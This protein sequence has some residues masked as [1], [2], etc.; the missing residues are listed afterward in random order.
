MCWGKDVELSA[1]QK[2]IYFDCQL[3]DPVSYNLCATILFENINEILFENAFKLLIAEQEM[4]RCSLKIIN[5]FPSLV[6]YDQIEFQLEKRDYSNTEINQQK[7]ISQFAEEE[8]QTAFD[9][10]VPPLFRAQL[11]KLNTNQHMLI[12]C[13]HHIIADGVSFNILTKKLL[14]FHCKLHDRNR[15]V[16]KKDTGFSQFI[17]QENTNL[18]QGKYEKQKDF[19]MQ[20]LMGV[21]PLSLSVDYST[22]Q[23]KGIGKEKRF[24][25]QDDLMQAMNQLA[26][27]Q[28]VTV[29]M[30]FLAVFG[31]LISRY[32]QSEEIVLTSPFSYRADF[33]F[34]E[35]IGCFIRMLYLRF[36]IKEQ[37]SFAVIL[38][39]VAEELILA[40]KNSDYPSNL[41]MRNNLQPAITTS[42]SI[43]DVLFVYDVYEEV[44]ENNL[45][46]NMISQDHVTFPGSLMIILNKMPNEDLL[47]IQYKPDVFKDETINLLGQRFLQLLKILISD[48]NI[49][50]S[51]IN[52]LLENE[53]S[54]SQ[55]DLQNS[56][57]SIWKDV[58]GIDHIK[59]D[60]N[61]FDVGGHSLALIQVNNK[62]KS[63]N[64]ELPIRTHFQLPTVRSLVEH[65][66]KTQK[67]TPVAAKKEFK[68]NDRK[69]HQDI[70]IIGLAV[71]VPGAE[72]L[73]EFWD[74][75]KNEKE[76]IHFY[77]DDELL[78]LGIPRET[79]NSPN[80][81]KAIGRVEGIDFFDHNF[82]EY[83]PAEVNLMSPQLRLLH[84]GIWAAFEDAG[85]YPDSNF[86]T[87][88]VFLGGSDDFEW[89][90]D[91]I[92]N[93]N[94]YNLKYQAFTLSTNHFLATRIAYK[95]DIKGPVFTALS[96]CSSTLVTTHLA[97]QSL[98]LG[99][100]D[101][102]IAGGITIELPN[103]GGY[104]YEEGMMFSPDGHCRP[105]DT[106]AAGT[107]FSN[108]MGLV[109]LKRLEEAL[110]D[111]D[112]IYAVIKGSAVNNDGAQKMGYM[113]PSAKGQMD[114]IQSAYRI[115]GIDPETISYVEAHGTGTSLGDPIEVESLTQAF[116]TNKKQF[117][118]LSSVKG[119]IGHPDTAA[120]VVGLAK[121]ALSFK[122]R[123]IPGTVNYQTANPKIDFANSPFI[124]KSRGTKWLSQKGNLLR[125][126]INSFGVGGTNV[127]MVLEEAPASTESHAAAQFNLLVFSAKSSSAVSATAK[128]ILEFV[129][130]NPDLNLSDVAWTLQVGRKPFAFRKTLIVDQNLLK[131][132]EML[133]KKLDEA[134]IYETQS[135]NKCVFFMFSGQGSQYQGMARDLYYSPETTGLAAIFKRHFSTVVELL[136]S[137]ERNDFLEIIFGHDNPQTINETQHSQFALFAISYTLAQM[138]IEL[139][140]KPR[141]MLGHSVG[142]LTAAT[143]AGVLELK[144][145]I[146]IVKLRGRIMQKQQPGTMLA[147]MCDACAVQ[148]E[149][150]SD[151]WLALDNT[152]HS[153][154]VG[155]SE[156]AIIEFE[157]K[158]EKLDWVTAR[159]KTS[160]AFH[161]PM[162]QKAAEEFCEKIS[163]YKL[164]EPNIPLVSNVSGEWVSAKEMISPNYWASHI[165]S[166]VNFTKCLTEVLKSDDGIYIEIGPGQILSSF[167]KQHADKTN[168]QHFINLIRHPKEP[169]NDLEYLNKKIGLLWSVGVDIDWC[170]LKGDAR[171]RRVSL[172]AYVFDKIYFPIDVKMQT[173][174]LVVEKL[175]Q[176]IASSSSPLA[177]GSSVLQNQDQ[178]EYR[179]IEAYKLVLGFETITGNQDFFA[180]GGDSL[181][182]VSLA[183]AIKT[184]FGVKIDL[185]D[186]F[187][188]PTPS[189]LAEY[190]SKNSVSVQNNIRIT[191]VAD[192]NFY[193]LSSAQR[194]M[195]T[196]YLLDKNSVAYNLPSATLI[197]GK[198]DKK[199]F[200]QALRKLVIRHEPLRTRFEIHNNEP[201]QMIHS[202]FTVPLVYSKAH[203]TNDE[204]INQ[205]IYNFIKPFDLQQ[206]PLFRAQLIELDDNQHLFLFDIHHIIADGTSMEIISR[207][208]NQLYVGELPLL[209][210]QYRDF[211]VWQN[212]YLKSDTLTAQKNFW[213]NCLSGDLPSLD[214]P[215]DFARPTVRQTGGDR[216]YFK[217]DTTLT[218]KLI[219]FSQEAGTTLF[220]TFLSAWNVLLARY[221]NQEDIIVGVPIAGR[222]HQ[223]IEE[224]VGMFVNMLPI[225]SRPE[226]AKTFGEFLSEVKRTVLEAF[227]NQEYQFD[228]LVQQLNLKRDLSR[229]ALFD[230]CFD[231]Q[232]MQ[233]YDLQVEDITFT[234]HAFKTTTTAY[235]LV[236]TCQEHKQEGIIQGFL[237]YSTTLFKKETIKRI[238]ANFQTILAGI[239]KQKTVVL[240]NI[241]VVSSQEQQLICSTFNDTSL[242]LNQPLPVQ[243]MF[244]QNA[245]KFPEK[246]ALIV[247][248]GEKLTYGELNQ[249]ANS[250]ASH[251]SKLGLQKDAIVAV[252]TE[253]NESLFIALLA[254][255]K[256]GGAFLLIDPALPSERIA[257]MIEQCNAKF[258]I[259]SDGYKNKI[260]FTDTTITLD[261]YDYSHT[262][263]CVPVEK[264]QQ[265]DLAY[266]MF[267]S[268]S[269]GKPK[270]VMINQSS[271][272]NFIQDIKNRRIF[273]HQEDRVICITTVSFDIFLFESIVPLCTGHSIYL[274]NELEQLDPV[275]ANKKIMDHK[276]T[277]IVSTISRI[278][279]FIENLKFNQALKQLKCI[280]SGGEN[281]PI[282]LLKDLKLKS[283][284]K[285][286]N[287]YGPTETTIWSTTKD[288]TDTDEINI[289]KPIANTQAYIINLAGKLQ[290][291]GVFGEL[292]LAG[293][294][295]TR[296]YLNLQDENPFFQLTDV[297]NSKIY[298]T[299]DRARFLVSGE[300]EI[301]GRLDSQIKLR[302]YRIELSEIEKLAMEHDDISLAVAV[303]FNDSNDNK[304]LALYYCFKNAL[305]NSIRE[306]DWLQNW[307][308]GK[309]PSYMIPTYFMQLD[310]MPVLPSGKINKKALPLPHQQQGSA[311]KLH[312]SSTSSELEKTILTLWKEVLCIDQI[313]LDDNFFDL[314]GHSLGL[315]QINN[316]LSHALGFSIPL[317]QLFEYPTIE[318]L[319]RSLAPQKNTISER[320]GVVEN[321]SS[322]MDIAVIGMACK[323]PGADNI[324]KFWQNIVNGVESITQFSEEEL[325]NSGIDPTL[326]SQ[327]NYI[328]AKG[329]LENAEF[330]D[331]EFFGYSAHE[332][333]IMDPQSRILHQC[334]WEVLEN[335]GY[336]SSNYDGRIGL[337]AGSASNV[338]WMTNLLQDHQNLLNVFEAVTLNEKDFLTTR[339][340]YKLN[341]KGPSFNIQT[342]CSTSLVAIHQAAQSLIN[343]ECDMAIAGGVSVSYPRKEGYL[344]HEGMIFSRDG[345]CKPFADDSSGII[346]GNGCGL[347]LLKPL[348]AALRDGDHIY[349]VIKGSA[350]NNDGIEK[351]GYTAPSIQGQRSVIETALQKSGIV[352]EEI[353]YIEAHGTGT[354]IGDPIEIQALKTAW[355]TD[356]KGFCAI[357]SV[358]ANLGHL[359][360]AAGVAS[361]IKTVLLLFNRKL[362]PLINFKNPNHL[363][364]LE[365]SPFYINVEARDIVDSHQT[366]RAGVSS[367]GIG[368]TNAHVILEQPP[369]QSLQNAAEEINIL[370]FSAK[371]PQALAGTSTKVLNYLENNSAVNISDA[372]WTLQ[373]GRSAFEY[374]KYLVTNGR[375]QSI[376]KTNLEDFLNSAGHKISAIKKA[377][378]F[379]FSGEQLYLEICCDLYRSASK[380]RMTVIFKQILENVLSYFSA[381]EQQ[382]FN[383][384]LAGKINLLQHNQSQLSAQFLF[385][386]SYALA[387]TLNRIGITPD[388]ILGQGV[389][390]IIALVIADVL[391]LENAIDLIKTYHQL[392]NYQEPCT[393]ASI[394]N[395]SIE[396]TKELNEFV[397]KLTSYPLNA[398]TI[399]LLS[400]IHSLSENQLTHSL[401]IE[402]SASKRM[403]HYV[404]QNSADQSTQK[405]IS[406]L[407]KGSDNHLIYLNTVVGEIWCEGVEIDWQKLNGNAFRKR[408]PLPSYEFA[409]QYYNSDIV[410]NSVK[411]HEIES[412]LPNVATIEHRLSQIWCE[413]FGCHKIS[414][415]DDFFALGG[416]SLK[417]VIL[418]AQ[419][420]KVFN[421]EM[422]LTEIFSHA[423]FRQM[424]N[425]LSLNSSKQ[426][427]HKIQPVQKNSY[428]PTSSAQKRMYAVHELLSDSL[429]YN[430]GAV[431]VIEGFLEKEK[432]KIVFDTLGQ[433]HEA[434]R[435]KF[436]IIDGEVVQQIDENIQSVIEFENYNGPHIAQK[437]TEYIRPFDL[438]KAPLFR[439]KLITLA[440]AKH[441]LLVDLHHI[442][443]DQS[444]IIILLREFVD[445]YM[446]KTLAPVHIQYKD[447]AI[448]QNNILQSDT[449]KKQIEFWKNEFDGEIPVLNLP[450]DFPRPPIQR[451]EGERISFE[452]NRELS[453]KIDSFSKRFGLT[454]YMVFMAALKLV[455][456]K[457]TGQNDLIIGTAIA[458]RK[459]ADLLSIVGMFVNTLAIRTQVNESYT[460][461]EYLQYL[462]E[463][464]LKAY[465][466]QD[467]QFEMLIELLAIEKDLSRNPLFD[468]AI[469]YLDMGSHEL[470]LEGL[471]ITPYTDV[472]VYSKFDMTWTIE[473]KSSGY[474]T[475]I[476]FNTSLF[477]L[478][479]MRGF[480]NSLLNCLLFIT[481]D[482]N[483]KLTELSLL[484]AEERNSI[485]YDLNQTTVAY[486]KDKTIIQLF[487]D[488]VQM[489]GNKT[490]VTWNDE[491][492]SYTELNNKANRIAE[493]LVT[494]GIHYGDNIAIL[495]QRSPT[496][497]ACILAILK[498]GG[499]YVPIDPN[500]PHA[501]I[502][503]ILEDSNACL[504]LTHSE[505]DLQDINIHS[506]QL[507]LD[508]DFINLQSAA[509]SPN[510]LPQK[511]CPTDTCYIMYTSGSTGNPKGVLTSHRNVIRVVKDTNYINIVP[512]DK[513]LQLSNYA[514]DGSVFDIFASLL[515]GASLVLLSYEKILE[516][517][518]LAECIK[519][520]QVS[521][522]YITTAL[523]NMLVEWD[524]S[525]L[526]HVRK[527]L[528]G[529]EAA[530]VPHVRKALDFLGPNK[531]IN[532]Y[533]P[534]ET[535]VF[536]TYYPINKL[537]AD[538]YRIPIGYPLSNTKLYI[539][540]K[541][542]QVVP[543][544][545]VGELYIGGD[546]VAKGY[547]NRNELTQ[548]NFLSNPFE[549]NAR[550]YRTGDLVQR[551]STG[552]IIFIGR[553]DFQVKIRG[554]RIEL[555]EIEKHIKEIQGI[556]NA[557]V[558]VKQDSNGN[559]FIAAYYTCVGDEQSSVKPDIIRAKLSEQI[560]EFMIP[561]RMK[562]IS[563]IPLS[564]TGKVDLKALPIIDNIDNTPLNIH[565]S[566]NSIE[567]ILLAEMKKVLDYPGL[568][569]EDDFF[570][571]GGHSIKAISLVHS[572]TKLGFNLKVSDIFQHPTV[573]RL[574]KLP[575]LNQFEKNQNNS[576]F[577]EKNSFTPIILNEKQIDSL[578]AHSYSNYQLLAEIVTSSNEIA[579][580]PLAPVQLFHCRYNDRCSG[581]TN[582]IKGKY[583]E[584]AIRKLL[585]SII[586]NNQLLHCVIHKGVIAE[587]YEYDI[588]NQLIEKYLPYFDLREYEKQTQEH[589]I[590]KLYSV[591]ISSSYQEGSLP[592]RCCCVRL[593]DDEHYII[594]GFD[595]IAF[596]GL[597]SEILRS[598]IENDII[599][600]NNIQQYE[601]Y[602]SLLKLGP[603]NIS[604]NKIIDI[605]SLDKWA[606]NNIL[607]SK[608]LAKLSE[609]KCQEMNVEIPLAEFAS[610]DLWKFSYDLVQKVL[611]EIF[612]I[613]E[614][615][616][617]IVNYGRSYN[618]N[619]F[620]NCVGEFLDIIPLLTMSPRHENYIS[621]LLEQCQKYAINFLALLFDATLR[622]KFPKI[623][624]LLTSAFVTEENELEMV[625]F[626]FQGFVAKEERLKFKAAMSNKN[627]NRLAKFLIIANYDDNN[628]NI[629]L[630]CFGDQATHVK[631]LIDSYL[632]QYRNTFVKSPMD[633]MDYV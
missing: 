263:K 268:G 123:F 463:K 370:L 79:I 330:F 305:H 625:L 298:K 345:H 5:D 280:I 221:T 492:L 166:P 452:I 361:F 456:W 631:K 344:W 406:L 629:N 16:L 251:I 320:S 559:N 467:C 397:H 115:A 351:I 232:N 111:G 293:R 85:Y 303:A 451:F 621:Y 54:V 577:A 271:V 619:N 14:D 217:I 310:A 53:S 261:S 254:I 176:N 533:G 503:F 247:S 395:N 90:R 304:Q 255:L 55:M 80:Y 180:L 546:G 154:V 35:S 301:K 432:F 108:G 549:K 580:F 572:L 269:T 343:N 404:K 37:E 568:E 607:I 273:Q 286:F 579:R 582:T 243:E 551:L 291:I 242:D 75:L 141:A 376:D 138:L 472:S 348:C 30:F 205:L 69:L 139:G 306:K 496:Q 195:Y 32:V 487:D 393:I 28:E 371:S 317:L 563:S 208:F 186:I 23:K 596:D 58:L 591:F 506:I 169:A 514:F 190:L 87:I 507:D 333:E 486:P 464:T 418:A 518:S 179:I 148:K 207:D 594:W 384:I 426:M 542:G 285:I 25:I 391:S 459:H 589:I 210:I 149:L 628:L 434:L 150:N 609:K 129:H 39:R 478:E 314:G 602:V 601:N 416:D 477:K 316:K 461:E 284:A 419:I 45:R 168:Q 299:G 12:F 201:A 318:S 146:E 231:F 413:M 197:K 523:F 184:L 578:V 65:F 398:P 72:T 327:P 435:T 521:V 92:I 548:Q 134:L 234:P 544:N 356:K 409:K 311:D 608:K 155:G 147:V 223:E 212:D 50:I 102:A 64:L 340:S 597:S 153:C 528:F 593:S 498:C 41:I 3:E 252:M 465:E 584:N 94:N 171:R 98:M 622:T 230:V 248:N 250:L 145:A 21:Q 479:T 173:S 556:K 105:F 170:V 352:A 455:L 244:E 31:V 392:I 235:D 257:Y 403:L 137:D 499:T 504:V 474:Q 198:L 557:V 300:L 485:V 220:M 389:G 553:V 382:L 46:A 443:A 512:S 399:P 522:F 9:L 192:R 488:Q 281:F 587:W 246:T 510:Y 585:T 68:R 386:I 34:E 237:D 162:M 307:L 126:G 427:F 355:K 77:T 233:F 222:V 420:Q 401:F 417:A 236:L 359:D 515:N 225:R 101:L 570:K 120:G 277:H 508:E 505:L 379:L 592:W 613:S 377:V 581:F 422:P 60:D 513:L 358:K 433:R 437:I 152:S 466:N 550:I 442:I 445:L 480:I 260:K 164:N 424:I 600:N 117:C 616:L 527:T 632:N 199:Q 536:A 15:V 132:P 95:L 157:K 200:E 571:C 381:K 363:I 288:L 103:K 626:N 509:D 309:L 226:S 454:A 475:D 575:Q 211:A 335:A 604:E 323:F 49:K 160:H 494:K 560:P 369:L 265:N 338:L 70:A 561:T 1:T 227:N 431:Y 267:T 283:S 367:F 473:K 538:C 573:G 408:I 565:S 539:L 11:I 598:Q 128:K 27:D 47:K 78:E 590:N 547:L 297:D 61:F 66:S 347:V 458:G 524:V 425:W 449:I 555:E 97:C 38:R 144:D 181:K 394:L 441:I 121:V 302:G 296:G 332:A 83:T 482:P 326:L 110:K 48:V 135:S 448:W 156:E 26:S 203:A 436:N 219:D 114:A 368:G 10:F 276:V 583:D 412:H 484:S 204:E 516:I 274:A 329:F 495:L 519:Q 430:L 374:R 109:V 194:R 328:K 107:F 388:A 312:T 410:L 294:G 125:A 24:V 143:I 390:E 93:Q 373:I 86:A 106:K 182:A 349:A 258:L 611:R 407:D 615:A 270:G 483:Q 62:L 240:E 620:Y 606:I 383:D 525:S 440:D 545:V 112:H 346:P 7:L 216:I 189:T 438:S 214:F 624:K 241:D 51:E 574:A 100:C 163:K 279:I 614:I 215:T 541:Q 497:I 245:K 196:L 500:Y 421:I 161:T 209:S 537:D 76:T 52:Q 337:F 20:K 2:G 187:Q 89:Y 532:V 490:A 183:A 511:A 278:K 63:A 617:G 444:S 238:I 40:Y 365:N 562:C 133:Y 99:E 341:L 534:T 275:L 218:Q 259:C 292:C 177:T 158:C 91:T 414:L 415:D 586:Q 630:P 633:E 476:E 543:S 8:M 165:L 360:S 428:Y 33:D 224:T 405:L 423:S 569:I 127:H 481:F 526:K 313:H 470:V 468:V 378:I 385:T 71:N 380:S 272:I 552:E 6:V 520:T 19:W 84:S 239:I 74:N 264:P 554:F 517:S 59:V 116:A 17:I 605:F 471:T 564:A 140:I 22:E 588:P 322:A 453:D 131:Q 73:Q 529:G 104:F 364:D 540:D 36:S 331:S 336:I 325:L 342:A 576:N 4:L 185:K 489:N 43:F 42:T 142:E 566:R 502:K 501:R 118:I 57:I 429:P 308:R 130:K 136:S 191:P 178:T 174:Q 324:D 81:V 339:L 366:L 151:V 124:V 623:N 287:M 612:E 159:V 289:G 372:A 202:D 175:V 603:Q 88:G 567:D 446:G 262:S 457:L 122:N 357:G 627:N 82:F 29:F 493:L 531:L 319:A 256:A 396:I 447:F 249:K 530:S 206:G 354:N 193:P 362:P 411:N 469:N 213:L 558:T 535:T 188:Y 400:A 295:V 167:A 13:I 96:G 56:I 387:K 315:I 334:A 491:Q 228:D 353:V 460:V 599:K 321:I 266:V 229:N 282:K 113:A 618:G 44:S 450:T 610:Q 253:R 119:N 18:L 462:K 350:I 439:A 67:E 172:P 290:P 402:I 375:L 595:H